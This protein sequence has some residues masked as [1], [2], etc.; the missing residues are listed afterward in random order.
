MKIQLAKKD[1]QVKDNYP[2]GNCYRRFECIKNEHKQQEQGIYYNCPVP[3]DYEYP[4]KPGQ[5]KH[6]AAVSRRSVLHLYI[7][8]HNRYN[9]TAIQQYRDL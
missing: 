1:Q 7:P 8:Q 6:Q 2:A 3:Q 4:L 9:E 5:R